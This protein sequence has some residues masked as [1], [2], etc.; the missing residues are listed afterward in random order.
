ML[1][2]NIFNKVYC[3]RCFHSHLRRSKSTSGQEPPSPGPK[4]KRLAVRN[5]VLS[6]CAA[7]YLAVFLLLGASNVYAVLKL[8]HLG[9]TTIPGLK[10]DI[11]VLECQKMLIDEMLSE[12]RYERKYLLTLDAR[13]YD[14][15]REA[16]VAFHKYMAEGHA[17]AHTRHKDFFGTVETRHSRYESL[18]NAELA[19]VRSNLP[20]D[21]AQYQME[22]DRESDAVLEGLR[23]L[24]GYGREDA[25]QRIAMVNEAGN[26]TLGFTVWCLVFTALFSLL[27]SFVVTRS[28]NEPLAKLVNKTR[29]IAAGVFQGNLDITS[30]SEVS[31]LAQAFNAMCERLAE[32]DG[33]K[34]EFLSLVSHELRTPL[35]TVKEG[36]SLLLEGI[37]GNVTEKQG[38][39]LRILSSET[40][41]LIEMVNS[42][43]DLSKMEAGMMAYSF[44]SRSIVPLIDQ[45]LTEMAPL[46]EARKIVLKKEVAPDLPHLAIDGDRMLQ[47]LRNL[48]GNAVKFTPEGGQVSVSAQR[49]EGGVEVSVRDTGPGIPENKLV[50]IFEKF[51]GS[52]RKRG[53]GLGL[54]IVKHII[55]AHGGKIWAES[56]PGWGSTFFVLLSC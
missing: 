11:R 50:T 45:V 41:R 54:A 37:C 24:G 7:G 55:D 52:D 48:V 2:R 28:I 49:A 43:L 47:A 16:N 29:E 4:Q 46:V 33:M 21:R 56:K 18:V 12:M 31:E 8:H 35:T 19:R 14:E 40:G 44:D 6:R 42:I 22:K 23:T 10:A 17:A 15:F 39:L 9:S 1:L 27:V 53:T 3:A 5:G 26:S 32:V 30:P 36:T 51:S 38:Q 34:N 13:L 25:H 20:Y